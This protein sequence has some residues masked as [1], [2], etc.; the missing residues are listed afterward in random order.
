MKL[1]NMV[2][3][4][5]FGSKLS[6]NSETSDHSSGNNLSLIEGIQLQNKVPELRESRLSK[7]I[8]DLTG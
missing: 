8:S 4:K 7:K 5:K 1:Y 3:E 6:K 2:H